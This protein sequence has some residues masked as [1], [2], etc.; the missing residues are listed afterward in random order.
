M[1]MYYSDNQWLKHIHIL[2]GKHFVVHFIIV[3]HDEITPTVV[4]VQV[5]MV[6]VL[7]WSGPTF[8]LYFLCVSL[9]I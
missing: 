2:L 3:M 6:H 9:N 7:L 8:M 4:M 5:P 1:F